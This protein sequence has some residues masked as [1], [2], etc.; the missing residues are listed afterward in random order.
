MA[1]Q[2]NKR[3]VFI[4]CSQIFNTANHGRPFILLKTHVVLVRVACG[5]YI[6][7]VDSQLAYVKAGCATAARLNSGPH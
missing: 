5:S 1:S 3:S 6:Y 4:Y 7:T 2:D